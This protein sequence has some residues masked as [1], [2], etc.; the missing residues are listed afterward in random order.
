MSAAPCDRTSV[1]L[2]RIRRKNVRGYEVVLRGDDRSRLIRR[3]FID[4]LSAVRWA[5]SMISPGGPWRMF[6][7]REQAASSHRNE[8]DLAAS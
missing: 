7:V 4:Y 8:T 3:D 5:L 1:L 6:K 2:R